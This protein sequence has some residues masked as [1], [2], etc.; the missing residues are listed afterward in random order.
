MRFI[1]RAFYDASH[2]PCT[3]TVPH[4]SSRRIS[5]WEIH[6]A[7]AIDVCVNSTLAGCPK[8]QANRWRP[9]H[10]WLEAIDDEH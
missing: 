7:Y 3:G 2:K 4:G 8:D 10:K 9:L 6:P 5:A 1:G